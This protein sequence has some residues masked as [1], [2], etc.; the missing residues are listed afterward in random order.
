MEVAN[1]INNIECKWCIPISRNKCCLRNV[2][3]DYVLTVLIDLIQEPSRATLPQ[4]LFAGI[5]SLQHRTAPS[6]HIKN[7]SNK[8]TSRL[9]SV[10]PRWCSCKPKC[11]ERC[12]Q[13]GSLAQ[14][15]S[16]GFS[17]PLPSMSFQWS[18]CGMSMDKTQWSDFIL[19]QEWR[20]PHLAQCQQLRVST[21][22]DKLLHISPYQ[23]HNISTYIYIIHLHLFP[24]P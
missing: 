5:Y 17:N 14:K 18:W 12:V 7:S 22:F 8:M 19:V 24:W 13:T 15:L 11:Q 3:T 2:C 16:D 10:P 9:R 6:N 21:R 1:L 4:K 23:F 20:T